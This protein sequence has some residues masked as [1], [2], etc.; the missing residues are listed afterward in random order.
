M[1]ISIYDKRRKNTTLFHLVVIQKIKSIISLPPRLPSTILPCISYPFFVILCLEQVLAMSRG[2]NQGLYRVVAGVDLAIGN[3]SAVT[4]TLWQWQSG[5]A[6]LR[7]GPG[8]SCLMSESHD[9]P[10]EAEDH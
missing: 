8:M 3:G 9:Q 1:V 4:V 6:G 7:P 2:L 5:N 10:L